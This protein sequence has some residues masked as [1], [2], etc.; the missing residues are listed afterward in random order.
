MKNQ[1]N[2]PSHDWYINSVEFKFIY[3]EKD[4]KISMFEYRSINLELSDFSK[5]GTTRCFIIENV[6]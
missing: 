1:I 3:T 2:L 6:I 5:D 4:D